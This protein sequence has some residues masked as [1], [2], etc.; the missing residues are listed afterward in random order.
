MGREDCSP[1]TSPDKAGRIRQEGLSSACKDS[2]R[3]RE[4]GRI[5]ANLPAELRQ[6]GRIPCA[7]RSL[8]SGILLGGI[9]SALFLVITG[10]NPHRSRSL[11]AV[12]EQAGQDPSSTASFRTLSVPFPRGKAP[13]ST[14]FV[15]YSV[16]ASATREYCKYRLRQQPC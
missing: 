7:Q 2:S 12:P 11:L 14:L 9:V 4:L 6:F 16:T 13:I 1:P 10:K 3:P 15:S 5:I 8:Y